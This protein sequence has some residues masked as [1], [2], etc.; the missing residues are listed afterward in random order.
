MAAISP[1]LSRILALALL[2]AVLTGLYGAAEP[3]I[4][5]YQAYG[6]TIAQSRELLQRY[7]RI[8]NTRRPLQEQ[9]KELRRRL[10]ARGGY[11]PGASDSLA[12]AQLQ[13]RVKKIVLAAGGAIKST[14]TLT[15]SEVKGLR[16]IDVRVQMSAD[17]V[18]LQKTIHALEAD[19]TYLFLDNV[20]IRRQ[21][22]RRRR[23]RK[24]TATVPPLTVR[25]DI[26][27]YRRPEGK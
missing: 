9:A 19:Q 10:K 26:Y 22:S 2:A 25:F 11:L 18:A 5:E 1:L 3:L 21:R 7:Q 17:I 6:T 27:G 13:N 15:P 20:D 14:Q 12:A 4:A 23:N 24:T 16:Q 8:G